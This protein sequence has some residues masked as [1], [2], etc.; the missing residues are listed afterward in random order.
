VR[1]TETA[2]WLERQDRADPILR[3]PFELADGQ[4]IVPDRR[5]CGIEWDEAEVKRFAYQA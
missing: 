4:L 5:G 2:H 3:E 1:I